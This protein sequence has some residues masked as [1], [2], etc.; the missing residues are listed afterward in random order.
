[1]KEPKQRAGQLAANADM[2]DHYCFAGNFRVSDPTG[3]D[4]RPRIGTCRYSTPVSSY[5][6][7]RAASVFCGSS[8]STRRACSCASDVLPVDAK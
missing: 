3:R 7:K 5:R 8:A 6:S 4:R 1:M 2:T